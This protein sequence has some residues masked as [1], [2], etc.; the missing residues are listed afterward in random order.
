M[1]KIFK[2]LAACQDPGSCN[3]I[4][5][6][7]LRLRQ[8]GQEVG[9]FAS[10]YSADILKQK[11]V[12]FFEVSP[13]RFGSVNGIFREGKTNLVLTGASLGFSLE[14]VFIE[15]SR[16]LNIKSMAI[17][18][19]WINYAV[20]FCKLPDTKNLVYLPD[21]ICVPDNLAKM[22]MESEGIPGKIIRVTGN[23]YFDDLSKDI[24]RYSAEMRND[25]LAKHSMPPEARIVT[26][27]SQ[28]ID[29]T[30]GSSASDEGFLGFTQ[31]D[32]LDLLCQ[33]IGDLEDSAKLLLVVK[34]HPKEDK[35]GY[36]SFLEKKRN[37]RT[38]IIDTD[39]PRKVLAVSDIVAGISS[40]MLIEA[41]ILSKKVLCIQPN[42]CRKD[43]FIL[44]RLNIIK[45]LDDKAK[46]L[47]QFKSYEYGGSKADGLFNL[48]NAT[49]SVISIIN[50]LK[51]GD[52]V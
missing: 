9:L 16:K 24:A 12:S 3:A 34:P 32:A 1:K 41:H 25:F 47:S 42:L 18:D 51:A 48:G 49:S 28:R 21:Y 37:L 36:D 7:V 6:V 50:G 29:K 46:I 8:E 30:F 45:R 44:S 26:F 35:A 33:A 39:D 27:F 15:E 23:P 19:S 4:L 20:R 52:S 38:A 13:E 11:K 43:P 22:E 40:V 17:F 10:L 31:F 5:P 14:D 2:V